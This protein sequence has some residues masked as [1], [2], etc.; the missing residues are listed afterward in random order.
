M[1]PANPEPPAAYPP[2][3]IVSRTE[4]GCPDGQITTHGELSYTVVTHLIVHHTVNDNRAPDWTEVVRSIWNFHVFER[5]YADLGYNYLID[6]NGVIYE[7]RAGGDNV[8][9]A[10]FSGVN[11]GTMG[12]GMIG[13]YTTEEPN[14]RA[15]ISLIKILAWKCDQRRLDPTGVAPHQASQLDLQVIAGHRDGP[16]VTECPGEALYGLL[17]QI[18]NDVGYLLRLF[19]SGSLLEDRKTR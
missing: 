3:P 10:H 2:P 16:R 8:M 12:I 11:A 18:R 19:E 14:Y 6:P 4:W 5:G 13:T 15:L 9:G 17:P 7:G 1:N